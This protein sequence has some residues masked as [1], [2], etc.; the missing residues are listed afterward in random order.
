VE[1]KPV[2]PVIPVVQPV[3]PIVPVVEQ[4]A[5]D[6]VTP[7]D[8]APTT[9]TTLFRRSPLV[10]AALLVRRAFTP[11]TPAATDEIGALRVTKPLPDHWIKLNQL[12]VTTVRANEK[13]YKEIVE[14]INALD[15]YVSPCSA[16]N[17]DD[18]L[19]KVLARRPEVK[20]SNGGKQIVVKV[21][22][23]KNDP[24][25]PRSKQ[26]PLNNKQLEELKTK[27]R[28]DVQRTA[29]RPQVQ[30]PIGDVAVALSA[31]I[32]EPVVKDDQSPENCYK[33]RHHGKGFGR[34]NAPPGVQR[35]VQAGRGNGGG[36]GRAGGK[37]N[38]GGNGGGRGRGR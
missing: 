26:Q 34:D 7:T 6:P 33:G 5:V 16:W 25:V 32:G 8:P 9:E 28:M 27:F 37:G 18:V 2:D 23:A 13:Q 30:K 4:K 29:N 3:N 31:I 24:N 22:Y 11:P 12:A 1:Q 21:P 20:L 17:R 14:K 36:G 10:A 35:R 19:A 15:G 38:A